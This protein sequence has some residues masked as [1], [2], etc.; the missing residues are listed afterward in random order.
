MGKRRAILEVILCAAVLLTGCG[1]TG[2]EQVQEATEPA[3]KE[4]VIQV[5]RSAVPAEGDV[6][7]TELAGSLPAPSCQSVHFK[8]GEEGSDMEGS[9]TIELKDMQDGDGYIEIL[10]DQGYSSMTHMKIGDGVNF[11]GVNDADSTR[12][13]VTYNYTT[14]ECT[15][16][17]G[18]L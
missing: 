7:P 6:W 4:A 1:G 13:Q 8:C 15:I 2:G 16:I 5:D 3:E 18:G 11:I 17:Y 9:V 14:K 12:V 10:M